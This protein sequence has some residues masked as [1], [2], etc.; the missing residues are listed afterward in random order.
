MR[1]IHSQTTPS[2][3]TLFSST[4]RITLFSVTSR[5]TFLINCENYSLLSN[6]E[7]HFSHQLRELLSFSSNTGN[8]ILDLNSE[9]ASSNLR[10]ECRKRLK[11]SDGRP[12]RLTTQTARNGP[13]G[14]PNGPN[15]PPNGPDG[16][17]NG[18][19]GPP[20]GPDSGAGDRRLRPWYLTR[21]WIMSHLYIQ[22]GINT[23]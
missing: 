6:F 7:N 10:E 19:D 15:G 14:P 17:P 5:I 22:F 2:R 13:D 18:P 21:G 9:K 23:V 16:P 12:T 3:I 4:A 11:C 1:I 8:V 20:N